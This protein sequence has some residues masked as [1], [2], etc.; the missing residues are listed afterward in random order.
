MSGP[1]KY[2][3]FD[4]DIFGIPFY[5]IANPDHRQLSNALRRAA[6]RGQFAIDAKVDTTDRRCIARLERLGLVRI[7]TQITLV[8]DRLPVATQRSDPEVVLSDCLEMDARTISAHAE[9]F[10]FARF[11][12][13]PRLPRTDVRRHMRRW[14]A[15]S[16]GG[17]F[18]VLSIG[19]NFCTFR[20]VGDDLTIDLLSCLDTRRGYARRLLF[21]LAETGAVMGARRIHVTTEAEN[22]AALRLYLAC[23]FFPFRSTT[24]LH[25]IDLQP[26]Q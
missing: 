14:I 17:T 15:N 8:D 4:S 20:L 7:C 18:Q 10:R 21:S 1:L 2:L 12:Q 26:T 22:L 11:N 19:R 3:E 24:C 16:L 23:G 6:S 25:R 9:G 13:D 5:R